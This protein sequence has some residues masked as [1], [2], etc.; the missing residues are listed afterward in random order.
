V[1]RKETNWASS[2]ISVTQF[3]LFGLFGLPFADDRHQLFIG[4]LIWRL[5]ADC[6]G[7][8]DRGQ[9]RVHIGRGCFRHLVAP[10]NRRGFIPHDPNHVIKGNLSLDRH[11]PSVLKAPVAHDRGF[12]F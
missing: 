10:F 12:S 9:S 5:A 8:L 4:H 1:R 2:A 6:C 11:P 7:M 3:P